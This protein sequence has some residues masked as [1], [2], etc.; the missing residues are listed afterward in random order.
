MRFWLMSTRLLG[1][2]IIFLASGLA[3]HAIETTP[4]PPLPQQ[5]APQQT[6]W[7]LFKSAQA[8]A[9]GNGVAKDVV[10]ARQLFEQVMASGDKAAEGAAAVSLARLAAVELKD[11]ALARQSLERGIEIG[12]AGAMILRAQDLGKGKLGD[13][14]RAIDLYLRAIEVTNKDELRSAAYFALGQLHEERPLLSARLAIK[15][16]EKAAALGNA[17]SLFA[18]ARIYDMGNGTKRN[19]A[20]ARDHYEKTLASGGAA[21][22]RAAAFALAQLY[23]RK[24]HISTRR[25]AEYLEIG[26]RNGDV[27]SAFMLAGLYRQ[28][29]GVVKS[30][31]TAR[32]LYMEVKTGADVSASKAAAFE[33]GRIYMT[34]PPRNLK[35]AK[36][37][38][39]F[40]AERRDIWSAYFLAEIYAR[41]R[42]TKTNRRKARELLLMVS[43]SKDPEARAA[44][45]MLM[46]RIR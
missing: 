44:A 29:R 10:K 41:E 2:L 27:W 26:R 28:G 45:A 42:P 22:K 43:K 14:K 18:I 37:N 13:R 33:L 35:L 15:H 11:P 30:T 9:S 21:E 23:L 7:E 39:A 25:A 6:P 4:L 38:F 24:P 20:K 19:W 12:D 46:K 3:T 17:W 34:G 36:A 16:H 40:A 8:L 1:S 31:A 32:R 5:A